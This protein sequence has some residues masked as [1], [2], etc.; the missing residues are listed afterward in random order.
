MKAYCGIFCVTEVLAGC[1][2]VYIG[3]WVNAAPDWLL[4]PGGRFLLVEQNE[5]SNFALD[6]PVRAQPSL[7]CGARLRKFPELSSVPKDF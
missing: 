7:L 5:E 2:A 4:G 3:A 6:W 1:A